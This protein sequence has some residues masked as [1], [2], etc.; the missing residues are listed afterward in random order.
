MWSK[1]SLA[2]VLGG[3]LFLSACIEGLWKDQNSRQ[4]AADGDPPIAQNQAP[5]ITGNPPNVVVQGEVY[6][7]SPAASDPDGDS[8]E[9]T[10]AR[11]PSW[12][13]FD[14]TTGR[15]WGTPDAEDVGN[16][17]NIEI[18]VSDGTATAALRD[19]DISVDQIALGAA[20]LSWMP[21]TSNDDGS[22]LTDLAGFMI[23]YGRDR[24]NLGRSIQLTNPGLTRYVIGDLVPATWY[25]TM[26]AVNSRGIESNRTGIASKNI[27]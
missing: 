13:N 20:T 2:M 27:T 4:A 3:S 6:E 26:T 11:K 12:A 21:P 8:L 14:P 16:Y 7:F 15:L 22:P 23:Y 10:I 9:F 5:T 1:I 24:N 18:S 19:F 17:T 25:F